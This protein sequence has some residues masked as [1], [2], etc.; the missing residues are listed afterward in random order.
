LQFFNP[1]DNWSKFIWDVIDCK[2]DSRLDSKGYGMIYRKKVNTASY[3]LNDSPV[4]NYG[5]TIQQIVPEGTVKAKLQTNPGLCMV[6]KQNSDKL[7]TWVCDSDFNRRG[8]AELKKPYV[9]TNKDALSS[10]YHYIITERIKQD[11]KPAVI[12]NDATIEV[13]PWPKFVSINVEKGYYW[14]YYDWSDDEIKV[15]LTPNGYF[16]EAD[17]PAG[18]HLQFSIGWVNDRF[19]DIANIYLHVDYDDSKVLKAGRL[20]LDYKDVS[21]IEKDLRWKGTY[22]GKDIVITCKLL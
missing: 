6:Y 9:L 5:R 2:E 8:S 18:A 13:I 14:D 11:E 17:Y 4:Y 19:T 15:S 7:R 1:W 21:S 20:K 22:Q 10:N 16:V 3:K 12:N